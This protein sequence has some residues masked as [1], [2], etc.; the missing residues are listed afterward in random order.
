MKPNLN[1][2]V[3]TS[4]MKPKGGGKSTVRPNGGK[5]KLIK[6]NNNSTKMPNFNNGDKSTARPKINKGDKSSVKPNI[7][8]NLNKDRFKFKPSVK[9]NIQQSFDKL[10]MAQNEKKLLKKF[11][12]SYL[13]QNDIQSL[14]KLKPYDMEN[15]SINQVVEN[16]NFQYN[17]QNAI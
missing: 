7:N 11:V 2:G 14:L 17:L 6:D 15:A 8:T 12:T 3:D 9:K 4:T 13:E 10:N 5:P 16:I 1:K